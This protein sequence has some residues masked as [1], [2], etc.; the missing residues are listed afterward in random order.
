VNTAL[1]AAA[2]AGRTP[3]EARD[4][5]RTWDSVINVRAALQGIAVISL[6][7]SAVAA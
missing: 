4:L 5:Q 2:V 1:T 3:A 7:I 6:F